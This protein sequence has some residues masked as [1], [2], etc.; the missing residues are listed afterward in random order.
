MVG[1]LSSV[2]DS[3]AVAAVV[4]CC[5]ADSVADFAVGSAA[6]SEGCLCCPGRTLVTWD[7][8]R[9]VLGPV[10]AFALEAGGPR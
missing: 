5:F 2:A 10:R 8:C 3:A 9:A 1:Y 6:G 7:R 4:A